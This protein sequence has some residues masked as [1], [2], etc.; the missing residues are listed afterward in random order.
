MTVIHIDAYA[1]DMAEGTHVIG[2]QLMTAIK[3]KEPFSAVAVMP[4]AAGQAGKNGRR[5]AGISDRVRMLKRLRPGLKQWCRGL[6]FVADAETQKAGANAIKAGARMWGCPT[7]TTD[8]VE[9]AHAWAT[10]QIAGD[11]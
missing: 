7:F 4:A 6:A 8:K 5:F 11:A 3:K 9:A 2:D 10:D 1:E